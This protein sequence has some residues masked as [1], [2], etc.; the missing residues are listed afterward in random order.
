MASAYAWVK[1]IRSLLI[2]AR[3]NGCETCE[4]DTD[5]EFHHVRRNGLSGN[6]RGS[7]RRLID[8]LVHPDDYVLLCRP[9]HLQTECL[10][11]FYGRID[12]PPD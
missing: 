12:S 7:R 8:V 10:G 1:E 11:A 9:C 3:G 6:G 5:L 4:Y 2:L